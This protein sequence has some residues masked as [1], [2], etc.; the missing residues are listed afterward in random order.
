M[1]FTF[2]SLRCSVIGLEFGLQMQGLGFR[3]D[4]GPMLYSRA[5]YIPYRYRDPE[6]SGYSNQ[7]TTDGYDSFGQ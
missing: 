5:E 3:A 4:S 7:R 2:S 1:G 6:A